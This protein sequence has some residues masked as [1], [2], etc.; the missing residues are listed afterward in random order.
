[1][2]SHVEPQLYMRSATGAFGAFG[3]FIL[4]IPVGRETLAPPK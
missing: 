2:L 1:M 3:A 4:A